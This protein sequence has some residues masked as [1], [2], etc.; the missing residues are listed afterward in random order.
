MGGLSCGLSDTPAPY[1]L[2]PQEI[3]C[4]HRHPHRSLPRQRPRGGDGVKAPAKL[5]GFATGLAVIFGG[6][7]VAG[8]AVGPLHDQPVA[9]AE[10]HGMG[11]EGGEKMTPQ[12]LR[13]LAVSEGGLTLRLART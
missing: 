13:G 9:A 1:T 12:T 11:M 6:A 4:D 7:A 5:A 2:D 10:K 3:R 8:S